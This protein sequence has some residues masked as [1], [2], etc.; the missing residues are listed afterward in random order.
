MLRASSTR[1]GGIATFSV[2]RVISPRA[3][4][5]RDRLHAIASMALA[6]LQLRAEAIERFGLIDARVVHRL[7]TT[8][9]TTSSSSPPA[10]NTAPPRWKPAAA[11]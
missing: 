7:G 10:P 6:E 1:M 8:P 9:A 4:C 5:P 11:G 2:V 3:V